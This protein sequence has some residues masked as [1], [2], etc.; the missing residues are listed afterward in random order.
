VKPTSDFET[1][2]P[3]LGAMRPN[4]ARESQ[5]VI[6][7]LPAGDMDAAGS[8]QIKSL[9]WSVNP[10]SDGYDSTKAQVLYNEEVLTVVVP[11]EVARRG[12]KLTAGASTSMSIPF[13]ASLT[14]DVFI[15]NVPPSHIGHSGPYKATCKDRHFLLH[16][17]AVGAVEDAKIAVTPHLVSTGCSG[18]ATET[19]LTLP[20]DFFGAREDCFGG[21]W[22]Y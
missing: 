1:F 4:L 6:F 2:I 22:A 21:R 9:K 7:R 14:A 10:H 11:D 18:H 16:H 20:S 3:L 8:T 19:S 5:G 13:D 17:K 15:G 12:L